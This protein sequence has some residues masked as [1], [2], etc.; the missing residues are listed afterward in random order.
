MTTMDSS[1]PG[2]ADGPAQP[3]GG[4]TLEGRRRRSWRDSRFL[5]RLS[6]N[7]AAMI[8]LV[9]IILLILLAIFGTMLAPHD[10]NKV[11][12]PNQIGRAS[13]RERVEIAFE[14]VQC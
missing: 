5:R 1:A 9:V 11:D 3:E 4:P 7:P 2:L 8:S 12:L 6:R 10:P 14:G 13:C